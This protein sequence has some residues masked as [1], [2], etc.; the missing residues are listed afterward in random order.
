MREGRRAALVGARRPPQRRQRPEHQGHHQGRPASRAAGP[1]SGCSWG[2][3]SPA[4]R[5]LPL[6]APGAEESGVLWRRVVGA[7]VVGACTVCI[8]CS[9]GQ[10]AGGQQ[11][12]RAGSAA[13]PGSPQPRCPAA[14]SPPPTH[15]C[16]PTRGGPP[17]ARPPP[18]RPAP[19][20]R[21]TETRPRPAR[22]KQPF[23]G[24]AAAAGDA[25]RA[26]REPG[27]GRRG[28]GGGRAHALSPHN[29]A[30]CRGAS[31]RAGAGER[32]QASPR[33]AAPGSASRL[34]LGRRGSAA[35]RRGRSPPPPPR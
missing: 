14:Q 35:R 8:V 18:G 20:D 12:E 11:G 3:G 25:E 26:G 27:G 7:G 9:A 19:G 2:G 28:A 4:V 5:R 33:A 30:R 29:D 15:P 13:L 22:K 17:R 32:E 10:Q 6:A 24:G 1:A 23:A 31:E 16:C 34:P 21:N